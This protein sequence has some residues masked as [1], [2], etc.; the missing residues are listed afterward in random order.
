M[1][2]FPFP[3]PHEGAC[4]VSLLSKREA[5]RKGYPGASV[6]GG[7]SGGLGIVGNY[8]HNNIRKK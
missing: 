7:C 8:I 2:R 6:R 3:D 1:K 4:D 5:N